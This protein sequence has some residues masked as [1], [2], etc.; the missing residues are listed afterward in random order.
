MEKL[1]HKIKMIDNY[2]I[3]VYVQKLQL[4]NCRV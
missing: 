1:Q 3:L 2:I 4:S